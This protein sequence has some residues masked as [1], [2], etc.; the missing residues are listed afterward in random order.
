MGTYRYLTIEGIQM[1]TK[2][3][4]DTDNKGIMRK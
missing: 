3:H 1:G 4:K 2:S